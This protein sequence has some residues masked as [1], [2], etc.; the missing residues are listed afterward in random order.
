MPGSGLKPHQRAIWRSSDIGIALWIMLMA[1]ESNA[2]SSCSIMNC[3]MSMYQA[4][5]TRFMLISMNNAMNT[6]NVFIWKYEQ[7]SY[8][9]IMHTHNESNDYIEIIQMPI[10]V[11]IM[12][13]SISNRIIRIG[14]II[15]IFHGIWCEFW[16]P[17][18]GMHHGTGSWMTPCENRTT[19]G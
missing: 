13:L 11:C 5:Q 12:I 6:C 2:Q 1:F 4:I 17:C 7:R 18:I 9:I 8:I 10:N 14:F 19:Q 16:C 3:S 15:T